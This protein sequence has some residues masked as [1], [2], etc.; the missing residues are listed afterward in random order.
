MDCSSNDHFEVITTEISYSVF[1]TGKIKP[2]LTFID[3]NTITKYVKKLYLPQILKPSNKCGID[4]YT[5]TMEE[6]IVNLHPQIPNTKLWLYNGDVHPQMINAIRYCPVNVKWVNDL[7]KKHILADYIDHTLDGAGPGIPNVRVI[8]HLHGGEQAPQNDGFPLDWYTPGHSVN[9]H[10]PNEQHA[11]TLFWHDHA[12]A[13]TRLNVYAGLGGGVYIIRDPEIEEGLHLP[14]GKYEIPLVITDKTFATDGSIIYPNHEPGVPFPDNHWQTHFLG[15]M[16]LVNNVVWPYLEVKRSL[17]RFRIISASDTRSYSLKL[18]YA[19]DLTK[20]GPSIIQIGSD[21]GYLDHPVVVD[22]LLLTPAERADIVIDFSDFENGTE[23][24]M[25]NSANAPYPNGSPP[26][27]NNGRIMK[28]IV[29]DRPKNKKYFQIDTPGNFER[30][31]INKVSKT[32]QMTLDTVGMTANPTAIFLNNLG[33]MMPITEKPS[34]RSTELWELINLTAGAH[35]I[36]VHLIQFQLVNR[37]SY[38]VTA[39]N[40]AVMAANPDM[41]LGQGIANPVDVTPFLTGSPVVPTSDSNEYGWKDTIRAD[42]NMV[43][44]IIIRFATQ[45]GDHFPFNPTGK[46]YVWHCHILS[47]EDNDMMRPYQLYYH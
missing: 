4:R 13:I 19:N 36:H 5:I 35:P 10:Y 42:G 12:M 14:S 16:I 44:R 8:V 7:S 23:F 40:N 38:D 32:R 15:L 1:H 9:F 37:Q 30:L 46:P 28:F 29:K 25:T 34:V 43:T 27:Q 24:I 3:P 2:S 41:V 6:A 26:D 11:T 47:H 31:N 39:Y 21:G 22:N 17:Y 18:Y 33:F 45:D 20:P